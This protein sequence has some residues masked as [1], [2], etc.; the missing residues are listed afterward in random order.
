MS[1][2]EAVRRVELRSQNAMK[3]LTATVE[4]LVEANRKD[5]SR[6]LILEVC[7]LI[8]SISVKAQEAYRAAGIQ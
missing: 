3:E 1:H 8:D 5:L 2:Q 4:K 6:Q 7:D